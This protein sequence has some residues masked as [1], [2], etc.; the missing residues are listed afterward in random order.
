MK[1][2]EI[3]VGGIYNA[4]VSGKLVTVRVDAILEAFNTGVDTSSGSR[5]SFTVYEVTNL[6]TGREITF[7]SATKFLDLVCWQ[8]D[9]YGNPNDNP[10]HH[11]L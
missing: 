5:F 4:R 10:F 11:L 8:S 3:K 9:E 6:D 7:R 2:S 1:N